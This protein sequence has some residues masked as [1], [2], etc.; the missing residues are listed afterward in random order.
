VENRRRSS[1]EAP[2]ETTFLIPSF[3]V[4][5]LPVIS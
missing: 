5:S 2:P 4:F 1:D 3:L